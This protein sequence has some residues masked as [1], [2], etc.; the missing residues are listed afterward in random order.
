MMIDWQMDSDFTS[1]PCMN[2]D[3]L[4]DD[5][6]CEAINLC[7]EISKMCA[8]IGSCN[9][10]KDD[11][12]FESE[13]PIS[14]TWDE[15]ESVLKHHLD[16]NQIKL[17]ESEIASL[18]ATR[19]KGVS[20]ETLS[21]IWLVSED[22]AQGAIDRNTQL[23]RHSSENIMSRQYSTNDRML[24]Y[25]RLQSVFYTDTMFA[26][27]H[28]ST[29]GNRCCQV[30]VSDK[31]F[32]A[33]YPMKSQEE[34]SEA[35]HLFCKE[36]GVPVAMVMDGHKAQANSTTR[37]F[38]NQLGMTLRV[39]ERATP[40]A[41]RA[42][43]YI[44]L[45]KEAVRKDMRESNSPM[46]LW[47][48]A[49]ERRALIHN[50][51]PRPL[52]QAQ[53]KTPTECTLGVSSDISNICHFGWY[54]FVY[55]RDFGSF[56][57]N[58]EKLGRV[59]GPCKNEGSE[60]SQSILTNKG[61]VVTRRTIRK[62]RAEEIH[63]ESEKR[64]RSIFDNF[65]L[66]KL[67]DSISKPVKYKP[68]DHVKYF[69][70]DEPNSLHLPN[71]NDPVDDRGVSIFE[72]PITDL[73]INAEL[74][75]PQGEEMR[76]AKVIG[77]SKNK[78]GEVI[79]TYDANPILNTTIYDVEFPDG[80]IREYA[81][82]VIA[83][84]LYSQVD[85]E[86]HSVQ[87]LD[88]I[89]D[90]KKDGNAFEK[91]DMN[92]TTRS[93]RRRLRQTTS[94]WHLLVQ[95]KNGE[96]VWMPL[97]LLKESYP[98]QVAEFAVA[99]GIQDEPAFK[100]WVQ[101][102]LRRRDRIIAAVNS[103]VV[104]ITHKYGVEIPRS[105]EEAKLLDEKNGNT[106]WTDAINKE[107]ENL[108]VAFD[109]IH[110][111][112]KKPPPTYTKA[113]GH[114]IFDVRMT[115]ERKARWVK[116]GHKTPEPEWSTY[117]GVVSRE[118]V[119]IA[120]TYAALMGLDVCACDIQ[121]AYL[122]APSTEKHYIVCGPEF[123]LENVG[124]F[125]IIV[126]ALYGGKSAGADY[127]RHVRKA[128]DEMGFESCKADPDV[129]LRPSIRSDGSKYYQYVL[130]YTDDILSI[131]ED[132]ERF[133]REELGKRFTIKE[134]S[135]GPPTQY[136]GNKV[137]RVEL[138]TGVKCWSFSSSQYAQAACKN[139]DEYRSKIG[140]RPLPTPTR[141]PWP[142]NYHPEADVTAELSPTKASYYQ[143]LIGILRWIV[144]LGRGDIAM[145]V[146]AMASMMALPREGHLDAVFHIFA[147]LKSK[148][149]GVTV[150]DPSE[151]DIDESQFP[152]EDWSATPYGDC[153]EEIPSNAPPPL[154]V[155]FTIRGFVD[156]NH[157]GDTITRRSRTGF[158]VFLNKALIYVSS[159]KQTSCETS[160]FGSEFIAMKSCCEYLR[161]LRF[162][163]RM[164]GIPVEG[165]SYIF[166][167]NKSV[168]SN[169]Q[170]PHSTLNKK[171]SSIAYHFVRE[172]VAKDEWRTTYLNKNLN[173]SD[174]LTKSLPSGEKRTRFTSYFLHYVD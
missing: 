88:A 51:I 6:F 142:S 154:G 24:R 37:K 55:Y 34:F 28:K 117:A 32:I 102:T 108:K 148:H 9:V 94:G 156:S 39:L 153:N 92:T 47:D 99:R 173:P 67:G 2:D 56:P 13:V 59:L 21:K 38:S 17:I 63:S 49:I 52:F 19:S 11:H 66:H 23:V 100:W 8:S 77:R 40:W 144:E 80:E 69:D 168:L 18:H 141:A 33:V 85:I 163:L 155:A 14:S 60:M 44:G 124:K 165:C 41:N 172:A 152:R 71:D 104:K 22:L 105:V 169:T 87:V 146:S 140:L 36:V 135:I 112:G 86:G 174:I 138:V 167:D 121:N 110:E 30:F 101:Y 31:G 90:F 107:M 164:M 54:E 125:A 75:L 95:W 53:G 133:I 103:R 91:A 109:I 150:F 27:K 143:S 158:M 131:M 1:S 48:Y 160:S 58:K 35:L 129:W 96:E 78:N 76:K 130:L 73:W 64:K 166:G 137:S 79:G 16:E 20:K 128:M 123:E 89:I 15:M 98:V 151:P 111:T 106:L 29:R 72:K 113:S 65:I 171:S 126:R 46:L 62:L 139:V 74:N 4:A 170:K 10:S 26:S 12:I 57:E 7:G 122:Q 157:A 118:S 93:G 50:V 149:N 3:R 61:T 161:G 25:K 116:D 97:K 120:L 70:E 147:F 134:K 5:G 132:P 159:K 68:S 127:W 162:K 119:R 136:L 84:N 45:L 43:L 42:E 114:M 145:E 83:E 81:A 82:N 115:L